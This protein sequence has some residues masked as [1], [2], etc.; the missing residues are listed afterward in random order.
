MENPQTLIDLV[1]KQIEVE[2]RS[3][4]KLAETEKKVSTPAAKI[5]LMEMRLDSQ[6]H[7]GILNEILNIIGQRGLPRS[8]WEYVLH[9]Y[10]DA[11]NMQRELG[12]HLKIE[13]E[14]MAHVK[15]ES[16]HTKDEGIKLLLQ[17]IAD[18]EEKHHEILK[19]I[20]RRSYEINR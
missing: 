2:K 1:K 5:F 15:E 6:K 7:I 14:M 20:L 4:Q 12:D 17:H 11:V 3:A 19:T 9:E 16:V 10:T 13:D 8:S 18:D